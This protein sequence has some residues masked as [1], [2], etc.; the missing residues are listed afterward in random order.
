MTLHPKLPRTLWPFSNPN[1]I[2]FKILKKILKFQYEIWINVFIMYKILIF[3]S[4]RTIYF[5][6]FFKF[7]KK[8]LKKILLKF[9]KSY[10]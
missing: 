7:P 1:K 8:Y 5:V 4:N 2:L 6:V 9:L 10:E 3:D